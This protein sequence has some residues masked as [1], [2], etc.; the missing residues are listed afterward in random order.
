MIVTILLLTGLAVLVPNIVAA[1]ENDSDATYGIDISAIDARI[2][3]SLIKIEDKGSMIASW[4]GPKFHGRVTANGESYDQM[5]Y[6][7]AHKSLPFGTILRLINPENGK[8]VIV[9]IN[10]RGPY[11]KGRDI[12]LSKGAAIA[13]GSLNT[14]VIKVNVQQ[15]YSDESLM[16]VG[17]KM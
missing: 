17:G 6:T 1:I 10:D 13:L 2:T 15:I 4:Y 5:G 16:P 11:I 8:S 14:G 9:R 12:D 3:E 7:A